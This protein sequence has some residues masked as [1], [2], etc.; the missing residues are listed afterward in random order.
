MIRLTALLLL[1]AGPWSATQDP[2][3]QTEALPKVRAL[4]GELL[5]WKASEGKA[6]AVAKETRVAPTDR[7]GTRDGDIAAFS[8]E[9]GTIVALKGIRSTAERGLGIERREGKLTFRVFDGKLVVQSFDEGVGVETPQGLLTATG[10]R[11]LIEVDKDSKV[12]VKADVG[13]ATFTNSMGSV[14]VGA[15]RETVVEPGK[16]PT[17][18]KNTDVSKAFEEFNRSEAPSNLFKNPGF[19]DGLKE[20]DPTNFLSPNGKKQTELD[21]TL[22]HSGKACARFDVHSRIQ[23]DKPNFARFAT[24]GIPSVAG[25]TYLFRVFVRSEIRE[26]QV[27]PRIMLYN[28]SPPDGWEFPSEKSWRMVTGRVTAKEKLIPVM[29]EATIRSDRYDGSFWVDDFFMTELPDPV[30]PK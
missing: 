9:A 16:K 3:T 1:L 11:F 4:R 18:P 19:E 7:L 10:A 20:W 24:Q 15:G 6:S 12:V 25:K 22:P 14:G 8:T 26:G 23:G 28:V 21:S 30:K 5:L 17:A 27:A 2:S 13:E 29:V